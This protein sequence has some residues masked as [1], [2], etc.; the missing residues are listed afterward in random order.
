LLTR[1]TYC[2]VRIALFPSQRPLNGSSVDMTIVSPRATPVKAR[3]KREAISNR[4]QL[5]RPT[6]PGIRSRTEPLGTKPEKLIASTCF[7]PPP[8]LRFDP[9][10]LNIANRRRISV[11]SHKRKVIGV[12][13]SPSCVVA[14]GE[15]GRRDFDTGGLAVLSFMTSFDYL[16]GLLN[17]VNRRACPFRIRSHTVSPK[18][19][20]AWKSVQY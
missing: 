15:K 12:I 16:E 18:S 4:Q 7:F 8:F 14:H 17:G 9:L 20:T 19:S 13:R 6:P 3:S 2:R 5:L 10:E 11:R 1:K